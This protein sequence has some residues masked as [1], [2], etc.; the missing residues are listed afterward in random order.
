[1]KHTKK[2]QSMTHMSG[3]KQAEQRM[4]KEDSNIR[5]NRQRF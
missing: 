1:M 5:H 4:S 3:K 2:Q